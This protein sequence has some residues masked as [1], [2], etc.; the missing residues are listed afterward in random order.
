MKNFLT[1]KK[2][3]RRLLLGAL[4]FLTAMA[5]NVPW[6]PGI[7]G[8]RALPL[9]PLVVAV[10]VLDQALPGV[11][12]GA[13]A[14]LLWDIA[15]PTAMPHAVY[16]ACAAFIC[17]MLMR[18][19]L[20]RNALTVGLLMLLFAAGYL[21]LRWWLDYHLLPGEPLPGGVYALL[22]YSL[23]SLGYTMLTA[24]PMYMLTNAVV[25]RTSR[26]SKAYVPGE[27]RWTSEDMG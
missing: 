8:V 23:P 21:A 2:N 6:L 25:K 3:I 17:A 1:N 22:R 10:A 19:V 18:Y 16:L 14:G 13:F 15:G 9:L 7:Y 4:V 12:Y 26:R 20:V 5:Q 24:A 11:L 27:M